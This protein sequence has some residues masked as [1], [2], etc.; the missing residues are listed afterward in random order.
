VWRGDIGWLSASNCKQSCS[1]SV[2]PACMQ[3]STERSSLPHPHRQSTPNPTP[4]PPPP[5]QPKPNQH[6][7]SHNP[8]P[9]P[10]HP[11]NTQQAARDKAAYES[12][13]GPFYRVEQLILT[14]THDANSTF[15][16]PG[17]HCPQLMAGWGGLGGWLDVEC[18][19]LQA[20][21]CAWS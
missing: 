10:P 20:V 16:A 11:T 15:I 18:L 1:R 2:P 6:P 17:A 14:T 19:L 5:H 8:T 7:S 3:R 4:S 9:T 13:F 21:L 12:S